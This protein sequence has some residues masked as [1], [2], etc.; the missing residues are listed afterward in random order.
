VAIENRS[1]R[2]QE[3]RD[4]ESLEIPEE[5]VGDPVHLEGQENRG[6][7][8]GPSIWK[9]QKDR[10]LWPSGNRSSRGHENRGF[11]SLEIPRVNLS[12]P[13]GRTRGKGSGAVGTLFIGKSG[14]P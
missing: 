9:D 13:S 12:H 7:G 10:A 5:S 1:S 2:G 11:E 3:N 6:K 8:S 14:I 4:I